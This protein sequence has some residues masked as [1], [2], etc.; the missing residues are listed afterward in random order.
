MLQDCLE[1]L[2]ADLL[3]HRVAGVYQTQSREE[4]DDEFADSE[5]GEVE[6]IF[7]EFV[8]E[9]IVRDAANGNLF[10]GCRDLSEEDLLAQLSIH[11]KVLESIDAAHCK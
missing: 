6:H 8:V 7:G 9:M 2:H 11:F 1:V 5:V 4:T 10:E 3:R